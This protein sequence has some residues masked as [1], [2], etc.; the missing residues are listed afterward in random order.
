MGNSIIQ[1]NK[2]NNSLIIGWKLQGRHILIIGNNHIAANRI[3]FVLDANPRKITLI[4]PA[5][6]VSS[7]KIKKYITEQ[8][9]THKNNEFNEKYLVEQT[10]EP[11]DLILTAVDDVKLSHEIASVARK[12]KIPINV[13][14]IPQL[15]DF[16]FIP[17]YRDGP[18]QVAVSTNG[19]SSQI[20]RKLRQHIIESLPK[21]V[22]SAIN[23]VSLI[24]KQ[25]GNNT[26]LNKITN[27]L[28]LNELAD[29]TNNDIERL[30]SECK[31]L[32]DEFDASSESSTTLGDS[33][34][35]LSIKSKIMDNDIT[36]EPFTKGGI[37]FIDGK[38]AVSYVAYALSNTSFIYPTLR[39]H[40][41]G[42]V[43]SQWSSQNAENVFGKVC[44]AIQMQTRSGASSAILGAA[45][46]MDSGE[47]ISVFSSS[48]SIVP[49]ISNLY[50]L[51]HENI[52]LVIH[53]SAYG[54]NDN[55]EKI[56][57]YHDAFS[58][59]DTG[60][61]IINSYSTQEIH[62]IAIITHLISISTSSS[63]LHVFDGVKTAQESSKVNLL[64]YPE[65]HK[66]S[67]EVIAEGYPSTTSNAVDIF[68]KISNK[69][70]KI[71][72]N[73]YKAFEYI[74]SP[75][76]ETLL[77]VYGGE[78]TV[79]KETVDRISQNGSKIGA[80]IV[81]VYRP[82]SEKHF[83]AA[84]PKTTKRIAVLEQASSNIDG[85][86]N[87]GSSLFN[88][89]SI[90]LYDGLTGSPP[91]LID[92]KYSPSQ[93]FN[94]RVVN[95]LIKQLEE[96]KSINFDENLPVDKNYPALTNVNQY[97]F[98][99]TESRKTFY[100][101][102]H[103]S[104]ILAHNLKL[105]VSSLPTFD[106]Y[107][108]GG[109]VTTKLQLGSG[110]H[111]AESGVDF[112]SIND[113][114]LTS[115]YNT[116]TYAKN[117][118]IV[119]LNTNWTVDELETKLPNDFR[120]EAANRNIRLHIIDVD[121]IVNDLNLDVDVG[122]SVVLQAAF[123]KITSSEI[124]FHFNVSDTISS[125]YENGNEK[126][127]GLLF[128][129]IVQET[130]KAIVY[131]EIPPTWLILEK[132]DQI[133]LPDI[134]DNS[135]C[136]N[137][138]QQLTETPK[139]TAWRAAA[140][141]F[142]FKEAY[143][144]NQIVRPDVSEKTYTVY[145]SENRRLTPESY[146]R[147][148]F[149]IEFDTSGT[150]LKYD[151][152]EALGVYGHN[153]T[154]EVNK[155][156]EYYELNPNDVISIINKEGN[157][158]ESRTIFQVFSQVL[159]VFG[160]PPKRFYETLAQFALDEKE[161]NKLLFIAGKE[162]T[163]EFKNRVTETSTYADILFEFTSARPP[164]EDLVQMITPIKPRHYSIA[165]A[166]S[167][168]PNSVHLLIVTVE[169]NISSGKKRYG[170]C[171]RYLSGLKVGEGVTV[172]IKP[173]VMKLP[174][175][176]SQPI[177]M[178]GLGTGMAPFRAFIEERAYRKSQG[179]EVGP[180]ILY[181]G[182]RNRSMEYL[183]GE[184]LEAYHMEGLLTYLRLAFSRDQPHKV[185][186]QHKMDEDS[187]LIQK[188]LMQDEGWFYLCGPTWPVPDVKDAIVKSF[189]ST[190]EL[191]AGE[192]NDWVNKL[193]DMERYILEVY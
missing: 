125:F 67:K 17:T 7:D 164:V 144:T 62:D 43:V 93:K 36:L 109:V 88:D 165:S 27:P 102:Q 59:R 20:S 35:M 75:T 138:D 72:K 137:L 37:R 18:L 139:L 155:F 83:L 66:I 11:V 5:N 111:D 48:S 184:E 3:E 169:W 150:D 31:N 86:Y 12:L 123:F 24:K 124:K 42:E 120:Y 32:E 114:S 113:A 29:L 154:E 159:D 135:F 79:V 100:S 52:P 78:T 148:L 176:D 189:M 91:Q 33:T 153:D 9:V 80:I 119:L 103:I 57:N 188:Y 85:S 21:N 41:V 122:T 54:F 151:L 55:F 173:S 161:K 60:L 170:Q 68:E 136:P 44:N 115:K 152:G 193:K 146:D 160:R 130:E 30:V 13:A 156:L 64:S 186:I 180:M 49:M 129:S 74:G 171:T 185:Y 77:I 34:Q 178:A 168:H 16:L 46:C 65:I 28:P 82:W 50:N 174:P 26:I 8:A 51:S 56:S 167:V 134:I 131:V 187:E 177:I 106:I 90:S 128:G 143:K 97:V 58:A 158:Y 84:L 108:N 163:E 6:K 133:L 81:R 141:N 192:A 76:A 110:I 89:V 118:T 98:W 101:S 172:S 25:I 73:V 70:G 190:G 4:T 191:T 105:N 117:G 107:N 14:E 71:L 132:S 53:V 104:Q 145:V 45:S 15:C 140:R 179:K 175:R 40:Y 149:H 22:T 162:G 10:E 182:S 61:G 94:F 69:V 23:N 39:S 142:L 92:V 183:Y 2:N 181:F 112:I 147:Y 99:D 127:V 96:G 157:K 19:T 166:Q 121:K 126:E 63:Y 116:L 1:D 95:S 38:T 47:V 87:L